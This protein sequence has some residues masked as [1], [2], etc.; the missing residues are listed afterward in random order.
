MTNHAPLTLSPIL[1]RIRPL[2][3]GR[4]LPVYIVGG[5]VRDALM[6]RAIHDIDL[7]VESGA[8]PLTFH[9]ADT[10]GWP[11]YVLDGERDVGRIIVPVSYTH[12]T[13]P[14]NREV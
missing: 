9:L 7:I 2:L 14:T 6:G 10:L 3:S 11:A 5:T 13:L 1:D 4:E 12:L 8:I